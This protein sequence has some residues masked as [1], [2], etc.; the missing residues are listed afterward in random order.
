MLRPLTE[1][2]AHNRHLGRGNVYGGNQEE[3][4]IS[5]VVLRSVGNY[6]ALQVDQVI[7]EQEIVIKQLEGPVPKPVGIA[8]AT[9]LGDGRIMPIADTA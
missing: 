7:G 2:L 3:D 4:M 6:L 1:L 5:V 9:V 8:G